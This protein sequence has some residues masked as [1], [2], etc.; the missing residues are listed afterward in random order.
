[1]G[2]VFGLIG[3]Q[4][5]RDVHALS[6]KTLHKPPCFEFLNWVFSFEGGFSCCVLGPFV[7]VTYCITCRN[8][9][10]PFVFCS[11]GPIRDQSKP[12]IH[13]PVL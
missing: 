7:L 6:S 2:F 11:I 8:F 1:M 13:V 5:Q 10:I 4:M 12:S 9:K 3:L